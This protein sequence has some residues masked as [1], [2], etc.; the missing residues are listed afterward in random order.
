[1]PEYLDLAIPPGLDHDGSEYTPQTPRWWD[2]SGVRFVRG[3]IEPIKAAAKIALTPL[4]GRPCKCLSWTTDDRVS[5]AAIGTSSHLYVLTGGTLLDITPTGF[6]AGP[7]A[8][9]L[10][11]GFGMGDYGEGTYGT[12]RAGVA[13]VQATATFSLSNWG[14]ELIACA[15][16]DGKIYAWD[17]QTVPLPTEA[18]VIAGS[19]T[20]CTGA[21]VTPQ[22][23]LLALGPGA[24]GRRV[25]W[26]SQED[27]SQWTPGATNSAGDLDLD[28][29]SEIVC[30]ATF[31]NEVLLF[32]KEDVHLLSYVSYPYV[33]SLQRLGPQGITGPDAVVL[34][35]VGLLWLSPDGFSLYNGSLNRLPCPLFR[36]IAARN[37][38][39][40][41]KIT[42]GLNSRYQEVLWFMSLEGQTENNKAVVYNY[43]ENHWSWRTL[44]R[45]AW[46]DSALAHPL[47]ATPDG[48]LYYQDVGPAFEP[49][50]LTSSI[51]AP[52]RDRVMRVSRIRVDMHSIDPPQC[53][54]TVIARGEPRSSALTTTA[55][56]N[57]VNRLVD[58]RTSGR[59][60]Q[61]RLDLKTSTGI[62]MLEPPSLWR[63]G[64][65]H[66]EGHTGGR[67]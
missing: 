13:I 48:G 55:A 2:S 37:T 61:L 6:V 18:S 58:L 17:P 50:T 53:E 36:D 1:M 28:T 54:A 57:T 65:V 30:A 27:Y 23:H 44:S 39:Q 52:S 10:G 14:R 47:S 15:P 3:L 16:Y 33:Y 9:T 7:I 43:V 38:V 26:C 12:P 19:P 40:D 20:A 4:T 35:P 25:S 62:S 32:T 24:N 8:G 63:L 59:F 51:L 21:H 64:F 11:V 49:G 5:Y 29:Q 42:A 22:R 56:L 41:A 46:A 67:R 60:L 66:V 31:R 45:S 34:T